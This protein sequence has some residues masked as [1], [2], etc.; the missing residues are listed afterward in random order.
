MHKVVRTL[1]VV[2]ALLCG[3]VSVF[4]ALAGGGHPPPVVLVPF[5]L[6]AWVIGHI[7]LWLIVML[8]RRG[9]GRL[10]SGTWWPPGLIL[11]LVG[12]AAITVVTLFQLAVSALIGKF[13]P[14]RGTLWF[15]MTGVGVVH[16]VGLVGVLLR[17][18]W[19]RLVTV[20]ICLGW[21]ALVVRQLVD[22]LSHG[23]PLSVGEGALA[24]VLFS[25]PAA[26]GLHFTVS[27][28]VR[29]FFTPGECSIGSGTAALAPGGH[30]D[31]TRV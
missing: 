17:Q 27:S 10:P 2:W 18:G 12:L 5:V 24:F 7:G 23:R 25:V 20:L 13:Y 30:A 15:V 22:H 26:L 8:A 9:R 6:V 3:G 14:Y 4:L 21:S 19:A 31:V 16:A 1:H 28:G 11:A 29:A